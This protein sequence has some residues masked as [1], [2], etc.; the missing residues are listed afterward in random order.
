[1]MSTQAMTM[2]L[3]VTWQRLAYSRDMLDT[4]FGDANFPPKWRTSMAIYSYV[5]PEAQTA[6][7]YPDAR[8]VYLRLTCSITGWNPSED[9]L[10]AVNLEQPRDALDDLQTSLW[11]VIHAQG[12][13]KTYWP[14]LG[15]IAQ[16]GIYAHHTDGDVA[17]DD[18]PY[19]VDFEPKKRE[20]YETRSETGEFVSGSSAKINVQKGATTTSSTE[21]SDI[22]TGIGGGV[23]VGPVGANANVGGEWGTRQ[24]TGTES[25]DI[26]NKDASRE[27]RETTSFSTTVNQMYQLFNGYHLGTNRAVFYVEPRPHIVDQTEQTNSNL[28]RGQRKLEGLQDVFLVVHVPKRLSGICVQASLDTTHRAMFVNGVA[29]AVR[30]PDNQGDVGVGGH[31]GGSTG[32]G[33]LDHVNPN[34][35]GELLPCFPADL[36]SDNEVY[37][38]VTTRRVIRNCALFDA[39]TGRLH[40][41]GDPSPPPPPIMARTLPPVVFETAVPGPTQ[42]LESRLLRG[43]E[44]KQKVQFAMADQMNRFQHEVTSAMLSGF[45]SARYRPRPFVESETFRVLVALTFRDVRVDLDE[46]VKHR[47]LNAEVVNGLKRLGIQ[48]VADVFKREADDRREIDRSQLSR[49]RDQVLRAVLAAARRPVG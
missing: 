15:A 24:K 2:P 20:L 39:A 36:V 47:H 12:W 17:P 21:E 11:E 34:L 48:T 49:T 38:L 37:R 5:V 27:R 29:Y 4:N 14:C 41:T 16:I 43:G 3:D 1:M 35:N 30:L 44:D 7:E 42:A 18:F 40:P 32:G 31:A 46:L 9:L 8:I 22:L 26:T 28:I 33:L 19:I 6:Q 10:D 13:A 25:V 23:K 45:S